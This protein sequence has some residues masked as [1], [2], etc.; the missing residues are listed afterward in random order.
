MSSQSRKTIY[1]ALLDEGSPCWRPVEAES[2]SENTFR[3]LSS[4]PDPEDEKWEFS[5]GS[6]VRCEERDLSDGR[7]IVAIAL[8]EPVA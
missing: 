5:T 4:N 3:I 6:I 2:L 1:V 7:F 8:A